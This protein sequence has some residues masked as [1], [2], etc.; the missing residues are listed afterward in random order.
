[1]ID[2]HSHILPGVDDGPDE[3][4]QSLAML[5]IAQSDGIEHI[6]ATPHFWGTINPEICRSL[7]ENYNL[8]RAEAKNHGLEIEIHLALEAFIAVDFMPLIESDCATYKNEKRYILI[9][10]PM[11]DLPM[12]YDSILGDMVDCGTMPIV[13]HPERNLKIV[14]KFE[15][16]EKIFDSG[17]KMQ[18]TAGSVL[19]YF[20]RQ[21][22][23]T[24]L[25]LLE[26][27]MIFALASDAHDPS[28]RPPVLSEAFDFI[29]SRF[30]F[31]KAEELFIAHPADVLSLK[32]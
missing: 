12:G 7:F 20:G 15:Y 8:L 16:A 4:E 5:E 30:G 25:K 17:A 31:H 24:S 18:L 28:N 21:I 29:E 22:Q 3:I 2:I 10:F 32:K 23:K 9:E 14:N 19:G 13:A 1:M 27:D 11:F 26:R 6:A